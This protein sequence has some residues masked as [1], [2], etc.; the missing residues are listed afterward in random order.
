MIFLKYMLYVMR[1]RMV[2]KILSSLEVSKIAVSRS[3]DFLKKYDINNG[4]NS[5]KKLGKKGMK[6]K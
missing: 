6:V 4:T 5:V 3:E 1:C 2:F